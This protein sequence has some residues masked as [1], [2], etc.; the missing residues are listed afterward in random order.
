MSLVNLNTVTNNSQAFFSELPPIPLFDNPSIFMSSNQSAQPNNSLYNIFNNYFS[1]NTLSSTNQYYI[2]DYAEEFR[3]NTKTARNLPSGTLK[4]LGYN[5][6]KGQKL[7]N[8]AVRNTVGFTGNCARYAKRDIERAGLGKYEYGHAYQCG[9]ILSKNPN[10]KEISTKGLDLKKLPAGCV[11]VYGR[12]VAG[13]SKAYGHIEITDG[14]GSANSDG[15]TN[16]IRPG[17]RVFIPV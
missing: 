15:K 6:E 11:L 4:A 7:A 1:N 12:G 9:N 3:Q 14:N 8:I 10:F 17:A 16:N 5:A 13:Y 2:K